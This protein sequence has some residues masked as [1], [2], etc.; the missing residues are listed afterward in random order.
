MP[1]PDAF[2]G[3]G[4][5][6][7]VLEDDE[8]FSDSLCHNLQASGFSVTAFGDGNS[9]CDFL[10]Q[11]TAI[12][13]VILDWKMPG[14]TGIDVLRRLREASVTTPVIFLTALREQIYEEAALMHGAVDFIE[15]TRSYTILL[16][17]I[18]LVLGKPESSAEKTSNQVVVGPLS[19]ER[20]S[21]RATWQETE[22]PLTVNE[23]LIVDHLASKVGH[24]SRYREIYNVI[25]GTGFSAGEGSEGFRSNVRAFIKRIREKFTAIDPDFDAIENYPGFGYRWRQDEL[26]N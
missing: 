4:L 7:V 8:L 6:V 11:A 15:K 22:V 20:T 10:L 23:F 18:A 25:H 26:Q 5:S 16:K 14:L 12:D 9:G 24:D 2:D 1:T 19:L 17:R 21:H 3:T 13:L